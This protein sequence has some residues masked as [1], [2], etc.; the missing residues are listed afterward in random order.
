MKVLVTCFHNASLS[1]KIKCLRKQNYMTFFLHEDMASVP[2]NMYHI[3]TPTQ[4]ICL[5]HLKAEIITAIN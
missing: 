2:D 3:D 5:Y 1:C 4:H